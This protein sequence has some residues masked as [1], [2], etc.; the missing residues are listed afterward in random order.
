[1]RSPLSQARRDRS[2]RLLATLLVVGCTHQPAAPAVAFD[3]PVFVT[4]AGDTV[5]M[6]EGLR[7]GVLDGSDK[8]QFTRIL[9]VRPTP[10][11]GVMLFDQGA[12]NN[13]A[14]VRRF[15]SLGKYVRSIGRTGEGPGEYGAFP[16]GTI[17]KDGSLLLADQG[18]ERMTRYD[19]SGRA[20]GTWRGPPGIVDLVAASDGGWYV[21]SATNAFSKKPRTITYLHYTGLGVADDTI[22]APQA[23]LDGP[24]DLFAI[25]MTIILPNGT[26]VASRTDSFAFTLFGASGP[27]HVV[28]EVPHARFLPQEKKMLIATM[29]AVARR[30]GNAV[31][32]F[33]IPDV[34]Q[35]YRYLVT[36]DQGRILLLLHTAATETHP[37]APLRP[38]QTPWRETC[39]V[40]A[41]D[42]DGNYLGRLI[43]PPAVQQRGFAFTQG[44][45]W[46]VH[47]GPSGEEYLV[48][49]LPLRAAW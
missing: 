37:E 45:V 38:N 10:N 47:E 5:P 19:T 32:S 11:N 44:A 28:H 39:Q 35:A 30:S 20:S 17:L 9:W 23:Y 33:E 24:W 41:F 18:L 13:G 1:M 34:K 25:A 49:W 12:D 16:E 8:Y 26:T 42:S 36:D 43:T 46:L 15:D 14:T 3:S 21:A 27:R 4:A 7:I 22:L 29:K 40:D 2:S 31:S 6:T 48:K